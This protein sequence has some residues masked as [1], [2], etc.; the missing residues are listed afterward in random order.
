[1]K[2]WREGKGKEDKGMERRKS[3]EGMRKGEREK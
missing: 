1:M 3:D 2:K